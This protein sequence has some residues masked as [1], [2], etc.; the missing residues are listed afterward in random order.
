M[1]MWSVIWTGFVQGMGLGLIFPP[2]STLA[3]ATLRP[4]HRTEAAGIFN[5]ARNAGSSVGVSVVIALLAANTQV[6]HAAL[7]AHMTPFTAALQG[8]PH[9]WNLHTHAG[10]AALNAEITRQAAMV[11]Y[12]DDF[13]LMMVVTL[14]A[15]PLILL[16][17][18]PRTMPTSRPT[19]MAMD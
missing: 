4:H 19:E 14:A 11:A 7:A 15:V 16:M 13:V 12:I 3:F 17:R 2:L 10:I 1:D 18:N 6:A 5:L 8:M 9:L